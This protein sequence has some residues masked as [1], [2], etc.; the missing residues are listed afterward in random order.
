MRIPGWKWKI[1]L[2]FSAGEA[3][4]HL[5]GRLFR[6]TPSKREGAPRYGCG[7][8]PMGSHFG[9][10]AP[11]ILEPILVVGL[12]GSLGANRFGI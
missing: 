7:S 11:P 1:P 3:K 8:I 2:G 10:G 5:V 6:E 9:V 12:G 4:R